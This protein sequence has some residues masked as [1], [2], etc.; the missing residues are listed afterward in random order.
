MPSWTWTARR[1]TFVRATTLPRARTPRWCGMMPAGASSP[2]CAGDS[3]RPGRRNLTSVTG[4]STRAPKPPPRSPRS[5]QRSQDA[6]ASSR[7]TG[8][9]SGSA[10]ARFASPWYVTTRDGGA[11]GVRRTV[12]ALAGA[13][14]RRPS[15][16]PCRLP[17]ERRRRDLHDPHHRGEWG[18]AVHSSSDAGDSNVGGN[19]ALACGR[20]CRPWTR[21]RGPAHDAPGQ[22][23]HEQPAPRRSGVHRRA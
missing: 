10:R 14:G 11:D 18:H 17:A 12:G 19:P 13:R 20:G 4:S 7:P 9:T 6:G 16:L 2:C 23:P 22:P 5:G 8:S 1:R 21:G 3:F 15:G